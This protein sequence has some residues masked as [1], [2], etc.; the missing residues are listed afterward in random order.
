MWMRPSL[1][2]TANV[3]GLRRPRAQTAQARLPCVVQ[4]GLSLGI[5]P[6]S[7]KR[8]ILPKGRLR[9]GA[10]ALL[11]LSP[12]ATYSLPSMPKCSAPPLWLVAPDSAGRLTIGTS[13]LAVLP[14][15]VKRLMRLC[16]PPDVVV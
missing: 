7:L 15:T 13:L 1:A 3:N 14:L 16:V 6:S 12:T 10:C 9:F 11:A 5:V 4:N 2:R 8:S